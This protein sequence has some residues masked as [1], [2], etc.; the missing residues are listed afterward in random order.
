VSG[1]KVAIVAI[2]IAV[3]A[4]A[5][6]AVF[7][8]PSQQDLAGDDSIPDDNSQ[9][10]PA[11]AED[12]NAISPKVET[13]VANG[14]GVATDE[15]KTAAD[16]LVEQYCQRPELIREISAMAIPALGLVAYGCDAGSGKLDDPAIQESLA[17]STEVY[18]DSALVVILEDSEQL[19]VTIADYRENI[20]I[21]ADSGDD[22]ELGSNSTD[23]NVEEAEAKLQEATNLA[24]K[25][26]SQARDGQ[27][28]EAA[29]SLDNAI[30][31]L[32]S[33]SQ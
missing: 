31:L 23:I 24:N 15:T 10:V 5:L 17:E 29:Q 11:S 18:C 4:I 7:A 16:T 25:S 2:P 27:L 12:C 33:I 30:K 9:V 26:K 19:L 21:Q 13:I 20:L 8:L 6:A 3:V 1:K 28:Y 14:I 32:D 22:Q